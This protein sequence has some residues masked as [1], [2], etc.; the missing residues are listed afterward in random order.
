LL[1]PKGILSLNL[2]MESASQF[3]V[4]GSRVRLP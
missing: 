3:F 2:R 4:S 1:L